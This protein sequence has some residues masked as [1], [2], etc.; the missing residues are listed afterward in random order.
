M[1]GAIIGD[2]VGSRFEF[3]N[4]RSKQFDLFGPGCRVTDDSIMSLAVA[5]AIMEAEKQLQDPALLASEDHSLYTLAAVQA[6]RWMQEVGRR[7]PDCGYGRMFAQWVQS[8]QPNPYQS[9]GNGAAMRI[10]A[11]GFAAQDESEARMLSQA[12]TRVTHDHKEG[13]KGAEATAVAIL[14]ARQGASL[15]AIRSRMDNNYYRLNFTI[16]AI[17][18]HYHFDESCQGTVPQAIE[19]FLEGESF[20]DAIRTAISVGGDSDTL[21]AITGGMAEAY[22]G[23]PQPLKQ[24]ALGYL[25]PYL[26]GIWDEWE[27]FASQRKGLKRSANA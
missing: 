7:Y 11:A 27:A 4:H 1:L 12:V 24:Q 18:P 8:P 9:F 25:D 3:N 15:E 14:M 19:A 21:A 2:I 13:L 20:E 16:D 10:S 23:V 17:R 5:K 26:R 22:W 6:V